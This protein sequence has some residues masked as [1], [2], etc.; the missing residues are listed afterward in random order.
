MCKLNKFISCFM[1]KTQKCRLCVHLHRYRF[2]Y[3]R[4]RFEEHVYTY[5]I[6]GEIVYIFLKQGENICFVTK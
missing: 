1:L 3:T 6:L 4:D 5:K 2:S